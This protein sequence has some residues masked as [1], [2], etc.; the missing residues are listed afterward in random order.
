MARLSPTFPETSGP[1]AE[2]RLP[3]VARLRHVVMRILQGYPSTLNGLSRLEGLLLRE[4]Q[5][6]GNVRA[7]YAVGA[8]LR[9]ETVGDTLLFDML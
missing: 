4:I 8:I 6:R 9:K 5:K 3:H 1:L 2:I 7:A